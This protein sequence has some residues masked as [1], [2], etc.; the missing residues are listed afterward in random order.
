[1]PSAD[2]LE[3]FLTSTEKVAI[4]SAPLAAGFHWNEP[5]APDGGISIQFVTETELFATTPQARRRR[6]QEQVSNVEALIKDLSELKVGD[7]VVHLNHGIGRYQGLIHIDLANG[8]DG[9]PSEF[10]HLEYADKATL[11][12]PVSQLHLISRYTG[13][14]ADE[15]PL[16]K[17]GGDAWARARQ[18]AERVQ[19]EA[20]RAAAHH[21]QLAVEQGFSAE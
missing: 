20:Q 16:H 18:K 6:K 8:Q 1:M 13:V 21:T 15:A 10:L 12:V 4:A 17:L 2:S 7:P 14:S 9:G 11:Y 19:K 3:D 5:G